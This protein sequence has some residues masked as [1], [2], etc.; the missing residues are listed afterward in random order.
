MIV[1]VANH[2]GGVAKTSTVLAIAEIIH[3]FQENDREALPEEYRE[4]PVLVIDIDPQANA[5]EALGIDPS[6]VRIS[7]QHFL[8]APEKTQELITSRYA[9]LKTRFK[10]IHLI[11][12]S[13]STEPFVHRLA[14]EMDG[15]MRLSL[16]LNQL[17]NQY[18]LMLIDTPPN[19]GLFTQNALVAA[20]GVL[21]PI[22]LSKHAIM[23]IQ[24][25]MAIIASTRRFRMS[26]L[27]ELIGYLIVG[28]DRRYNLHQSLEIVV[29]QTFGTDVFES[30]I[31]TQAKWA[32]NVNKRRP[33]FYGLTTEQKD[34]WLSFIRE[35]FERTEK[36]VPVKEK[37]V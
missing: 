13:I 24:N 35:L 4:K 25:L 1:T 3:W 30:V 20:D 19:L 7:V 10:N 18:P 22:S 29:R 11:P 15:A 14:G 33:I 2:K 23:G 37:A 36:I 5:T 26:H 34:E 17:V 27:P 9:I 16:V 32:E 12:T 6:E 31:P 21:V 28:L 8:E